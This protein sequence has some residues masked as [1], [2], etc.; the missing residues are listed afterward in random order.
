MKLNLALAQD[1]G[2]HLKHILALLVTRLVH[3]VYSRVLRM[4]TLPTFLWLR[5]NIIWCRRA[6]AEPHRR[7]TVRPVL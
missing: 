1:L 2:E 4:V 7:M 6:E 3:P 5:L